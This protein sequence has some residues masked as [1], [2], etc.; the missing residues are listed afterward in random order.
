MLPWVN[1]KRE[2]CLVRENLEEFFSYGTGD[3]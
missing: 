1:G 3:D 2:K